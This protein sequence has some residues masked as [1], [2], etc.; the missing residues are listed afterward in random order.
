MRIIPYLLFTGCFLAHIASGAAPTEPPWC[1]PQAF[2]QYRIYKSS[3]ERVNIF[4][5]GRLRLAG[6]PVGTLG[7]D[8]VREIAE[9]FSRAR[10]RDRF[11]TWYVNVSS[12]E[13]A[14]EFFHRPPPAPASPVA[15]KF[16]NEYMKIL[17]QDFGSGR[18][19]FLH[20]AEKFDYVAIGCDVMRH[21]GPTVFAMFLSFSG[22]TPYHAT[23]I[24]NQYWG[25]NWI[26]F[27]VRSGIVQGAYEHGNQNPALRHRLQRIMQARA[28]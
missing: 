15:G 19:S 21:R 26:P 25:L 20:C 2:N 28:L 4:Q 12:L 8:R 10:A 27:W 13:A 14:D 3:A 18:E 24:A 7:T 22:C 23:R 5:I 6:M 17:E 16:K 11:C 1:R 9:D